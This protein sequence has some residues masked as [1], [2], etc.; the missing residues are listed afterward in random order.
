MFSG[1]PVRV[2]LDYGN[3]GTADLLANVSGVAADGERLWT[4]ADE[5][6]SVECLRPDGNGGFVIESQT[7]LDDVIVD[8]PGA[9][10]GKELD[11][12]AIDFASGVLWL[13]GSHCRVRKEI[14]GK[15][16]ATSEVRDRPSRQLLARLDVV[17]A[18][19]RGGRALPFKGQGSLRG[20]LAKDARLA[21]FL[22]LPTKENGLDIEGM[23][24]VDNV[25]RLGLRGPV[26]DGAAVVVRLE[27][28]DML[29]RC[30][31]SLA[32]LDLGGLGIRDLCRTE[33]GFLV[34]AGPVGKVGGPFRLHHWRDDGSDSLQQP[35]KV[36]DWPAGGEKPEG[37][38]PLMR[39]GKPGLLVLYDEPRA[40]RVTGGIYE[41]DW[42]PA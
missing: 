10:K 27:V 8:I 40:G 1:E 2:A 42:L 31:H 23:A 9:D 37:I 16:A 36:Y 13:A 24:V 26:V 41:A 5:G 25:V 21:P 35:D 22:A 12:E 34:L 28:D 4:I 20:I 19:Y 3:A 33:E 30:R 39:Q 11:L 32:L 14:E 38:C 15:D 17:G 29:E 18:E 7:A 6:R